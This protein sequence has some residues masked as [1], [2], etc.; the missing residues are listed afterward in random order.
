M[1]T[2]LLCIL[3]LFLV[4]PT[5]VKAEHEVIDARCTLDIKMSLRENARD[6]NYKLTRNEDKKGNVTYSITLFNITGS[7]S[8]KSSPNSLLSLLSYTAFNK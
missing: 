4:V 1:K 6:I 3:I 7:T 8:Y 2:R 5:F